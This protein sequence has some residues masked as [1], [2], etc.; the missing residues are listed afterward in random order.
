L[1]P[2]SQVVM[3]V[4]RAAVI[5]GVA[6]ALVAA[7]AGGAGAAGFASAEFGGE[8]GH[9]VATNP[10]ALYFNPAGI[11]FSEGTAFYAGGVVALRRGAWT[12]GQAA[13][14]A[15]PPPGAEGADTGQAR[16]SNV[17][18]AP[19]LGGTSRLGRVALG[20]AFYVPFGGRLAWDKNQRFV[21]D[22][23]FPLA[24]DGVQRWTITEGALTYLYFTAG[25]AV[26]FGRLAVG[27]TGNLVHSSVK[28]TQAK[29]A[30]PQ[31]DVDPLNEYRVRI[32]VGGLQASF[33]V[34]AMFEAVADRL[35]LGASYQA[36][37]GLGPID[38]EG[39]LTRTQGAASRADDVTYR[40]AL[41]DVVR[42]G[43]RLR[44]TPAVELR[45]FGDITR[46][47]R[48]QT[49]CLSTRGQPCAVLPSGEA[50]NAYTIQNLRRHW[51]DTFGVRAGVSVWPAPALELLAG[52]GYETAA[53]P[54]ATLD[55]ALPDAATLR[56]A[57]GARCALGGGWRV[58]LGLTGV[59]HFTRDNT[60]RSALAAED[61]Q[62]PTRRADGGGRY[63]LWLG[64]G[65]ISLEKQ[66]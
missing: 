64:L 10:T 25:A 60:G 66:L 15:S 55:P 42:L 32:D 61:V 20:G 5:A 18:G 47:S 62:L 19:V 31:E 52:V 17:F 56:L 41:P 4:R 23:T 59:Q 28:L 11:A 54:D 2:A 36:P 53:T 40:Q 24:A 12:H 27:L 44:A 29:S 50:A 49:E 6:L 58:G 34:G 48:L 45:L 43:A 21:G 35:W 57:L 7:A 14:E 13:T 33:G 26:R 30:N 63:T 39:T 37:P 3:V 46:W 51:R 8:Q 38:L 9:V 16:F 1:E 22:P 65:Q